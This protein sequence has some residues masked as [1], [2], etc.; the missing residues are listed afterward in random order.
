MYSTHGASF[1][2]LCTASC[3]KED[4]A[5]H[6]LYL[7]IDFSVFTSFCIGVPLVASMSIPTYTRSCLSKGESPTETPDAHTLFPGSRSHTLLYHKP[8]ASL[9]H[10]TS[11][12][13][14]FRIL[15]L[16]PAIGPV[17]L[18]PFP[19]LINVPCESLTWLFRTPAPLAASWCTCPA[20]SPP[21][22]P[23]PFVFSSA[24]RC[25]AASFFCHAAYHTENKRQAV[26][27]SSSPFLPVTS[28]RER[29]S[30]HYTE[31]G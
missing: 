23:W 21:T 4:L 20:A 10:K 15:L 22:M 30:G 29:V 1:C 3:D 12:Q 13:P 7:H 2:S 27:Q 26:N 18:F 16:P 19:P 31:R 11:Q 24:L 9:Q 8:A 14:N 25:L 5:I 6:L 17:P 28:Q